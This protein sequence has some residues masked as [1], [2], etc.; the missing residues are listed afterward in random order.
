MEGTGQGLDTGGYEVP[1]INTTI[2]DEYGC[3]SGKH[4]L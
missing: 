2:E 3:K 1:V 4:T